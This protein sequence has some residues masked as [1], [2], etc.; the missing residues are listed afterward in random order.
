MSIKNLKKEIKNKIYPDD[1]VLIV[2]LEVLNNKDFARYNPVNIHKGFYSYKQ[3]KRYKKLLNKFYFNPS[4]ISPFSNQISKAIFRIQLSGILLTTAPEF[5]CFI[6]KNRNK[7]KEKVR[8]KFT[9][10]ELR[11]MQ[12][13]AQKISQFNKKGS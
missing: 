8:K 2:L 3:K 13:I 4:T 5:N 1:I 12:E 7:I 6:I 10:K 11:Q 9:E